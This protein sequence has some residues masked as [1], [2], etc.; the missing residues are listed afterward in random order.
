M[1]KPQFRLGRAAAFPDMIP[2][3]QSKSGCPNL[4][5]PGEALVF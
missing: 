4:D 1:K 3:S 5:D 2:P